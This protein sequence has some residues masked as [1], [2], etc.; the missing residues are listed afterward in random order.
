M[1]QL[2]KWLFLL[3]AL[4]SFSF[5]VAAESDAD[6]KIQF[7]EARLQRDP[8]DH[9]T[10]TQLGSAYLQ[11]ARESGD[12]TFYPKAETAFR[13]ALARNP[14]HSTAQSLLAAALISQ[15]RFAEA[16]TNAEIV[17][18]KSPD[19]FFTHG[20]LG[21]A[22]LETGDTAKA[23]AA[24]KKM[25]KLNPSLFAYSRIANLKYLRGDISGSLDNFSEA[26]ES[27]E[28]ESAS[29]ESLAWCHT[30]KGEIHFRTGDFR[31]AAT[32][33]DAAL[34]IFPD[35]F[36][37]WEH[38]AELRAAETN[39]TEAISLYKK[40]IERVPRPEFQ[41][42]LGDVYTFMGKTTDAKPWHD[43]ALKGYLDAADRGQMH[44]YHHL[45]TFYCDVHR[46]SAEALKWA[47]K[48]FEVRKNV[49]ACDALAWALFQ[50][51]EFESAAE[52]MK[53][54]LALGTRDAH[55][56]FHASMIYMRG[57]NPVEGKK[58][59]R[60]IREINPR[61]ETFHAHR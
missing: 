37:A 26:I 18:K 61:Y 22:A 28:R 1:R 31:Q 4:S 21:D 46:D 42:A 10:P 3:A 32:N 23:E 13:T 55:L 49:F 43:C 15:H 45:A 30:Q 7:L 56:F 2:F 54:T 19:D 58:L 16:I 50:N 33:Y 48:D 36:S 44:Y 40:A 6:Q 17:I 41:Q 57:G 11:K 12:L 52:I 60:E 20:V 47:R 5:S 25:L 8:S 35:Y 39:F 53:K 27:G 29:K 14:Q 24:Y 59:L 9:I 34:K 38:L 51:A